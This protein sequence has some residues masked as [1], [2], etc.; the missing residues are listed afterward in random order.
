M[1]CSVALEKAVAPF[2]GLWF[3]LGQV[4]QL[5][6]SQVQ[7]RVGPT[8]P[9][10]E[11]PPRPA[12]TLSPWPAEGT[13]AQ[14]I[15]TV[16]GS[17]V[18]WCFTLAGACFC[19]LWHRAALLRVAKFNFGMMKTRDPGMKGVVGDSLDAGASW[20]GFRSQLPRSLAV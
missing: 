4:E 16:P 10:S 14:E 3:P 15:H 13:P 18:S 2:S 5:S 9:C 7:V 20:S 11:D 8:S 6:G 19:Q 1:D 17:E 12:G